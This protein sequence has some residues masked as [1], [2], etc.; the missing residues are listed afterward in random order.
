[1]LIF[2]IFYISIEN[3]TFFILAAYCNMCSVHRHTII[4]LWCL[5][6]Y[7]IINLVSFVLIVAALQNNLQN[8]FHSCNNNMFT[9]YYY[10]NSKLPQSLFIYFSNCYTTALSRQVQGVFFHLG[11]PILS[12]FLLFVVYRYIGIRY[13]YI[14]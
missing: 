5:L 13:I 4:I 9:R 8:M 2:F 11:L 10:N 7:M 1:M 12:S 6:L 14:Q 3:L